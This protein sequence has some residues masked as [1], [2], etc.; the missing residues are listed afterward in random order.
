MA[1]VKSGQ[2]FVFLSNPGGCVVAGLTRV[3]P[4]G[5]ASKKSMNLKQSVYNAKQCGETQKDGAYLCSVSEKKSELLEMLI[6]SVNPQIDTVR[7]KC[8]LNNLELC[9]YLRP[10]KINSE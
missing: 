1:W 4:K 9:D 10:K 6:L 7:S 2:G 5:V 3:P 8:E